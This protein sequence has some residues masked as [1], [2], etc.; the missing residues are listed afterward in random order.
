MMLLMILNLSNLFT[1]NYLH[2]LSKMS[3]LKAS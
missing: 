1:S 2:I 3:G